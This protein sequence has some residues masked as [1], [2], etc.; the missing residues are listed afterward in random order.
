MKDD[1]DKKAEDGVD[2]TKTGADDGAGTGG[3]GSEG[4]GAEGSKAQ[5]WTSALPKE[6]R[7]EAAGRWGSLREMAEAALGRRGKPEEPDTRESVPEAK[8]P[9]ES[10]ETS[11]RKV[12]GDDFDSNLEKAK[13]SMADVK[14]LNPKLV[15]RM[16]SEDGSLSADM[17][18][19]FA[20][21][22]RTEPG[23]VTPKETSPASKVDFKGG[24]PNRFGIP[25]L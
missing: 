23:T 4:S 16:L 10:L 22:A 15:E 1:E 19:L 8:T 2:E 12:W 13:R 25:G 17:M 9:K 20:T 11:L 24:I 7:D 14:R 5:G 6:L 3:R 18:D 21:L